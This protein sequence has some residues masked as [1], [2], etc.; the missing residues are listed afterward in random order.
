MNIGIIGTGRIA[1]SRVKKLL[2]LDDVRFHWVCSRKSD[3]AKTFLEE[4]G[5]EFREKTESTLTLENWREAVGVPD[6]DGVYIA[7]PNTLHYSMAR[8]AL[9]NGRHVLL[10]YPHATDVADGKKLLDMSRKK[11]LVLHVGLTYRYSGK[12]QTLRNILHS[13]NDEYGIGEPHAWVFTDPAGGMISRWYDR[14]ELTGGTYISSVFDNLD[15]VIGYFGRVKN[16]FSHYRS[17][18]DQDGVIQED[19]AALMLV[20][21]SGCTAQITYTR[22]YPKPGLTVQK[23]IICE[24]GHVDLVGEGIRIVSGGQ[25]RV[26]IPKAV[27]ALQD[28]TRDFI[29]GVR[30]SKNID[31]TA[32]DAQ[33]ALEIAAKAQQAANR[34]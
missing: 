31:T 13:E 3:R 10:E 23:I 8:A 30:V 25:E 33:Y 19:C 22:G 12:F 21:E 34:R 17:V 11:N 14:D 20:F 26:V 6:T 1:L 29:D 9:E 15:E 28:E 2:S 32:S 5:Q 7:T 27:D 18:R 16:L 24:K 4:I